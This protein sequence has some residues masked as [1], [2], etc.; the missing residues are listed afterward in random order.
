MDLVISAV[1]SDLASRFISFI[2]NRL[3]ISSCAEEKVERLQRLLQRVETVVEEANGRYIPN[4]VM[5]SQL[6]ILEEAMYLSYHTLYTFKYRGLEG[7]KKE[8]TDGS[9]SLY[10]SSPLKHSA[11]S[12]VQC[13]FD[14]GDKL[15][16]AMASL[17]AVVTNMTEFVMLLGGCERMSR[18]PYDTYLY[19]E[20]FMFGRHA[21]MQ[22]A[23]NILL[24]PP[25][26]NN[27]PTVLPIIGGRFIG[28]KTLVAHQHKSDNLQ[29]MDSQR[30]SSGRALI[31]VELTTDI[32]DEEWAKFYSSVPEMGEGSKVI[33][34]TRLRNLSRFGSTNMEDHPR[35]ASMVQE[36]PLLLRGSLISAYAFAD[37]L[38]R[39]LS[40]LF[41]A[42]VLDRFRGVVESNLSLFG[43][44]PK[45]LLDRDLP[46]DMARFI[47]PSAAPLR[48]MPPRSEADTQERPLP[49]LTFGE[50]I[51][52]PRILPRGDFDLVTW[53][54]K[55][56]PYSKYV[57]FVPVAYAEEKPEMWP[58]RRKRRAVSL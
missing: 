16:S 10:F 12:A 50:L 6:R 26:N 14:N 42:S 49:M 37:I 3:S 40:P 5:L 39:N 52:D 25:L 36:F 31:I 32:G 54:S 41:W 1:A 35:L 24:Q 7:A 30:H 13:S 45:L 17:E 18:R 27:A 38:K 21:E 22:Q 15:Q 2:I 57:H 19:M 8:V 55:I 51:E 56:A 44:H 43:E 34:I 11:G 53:E 20:N 48:L 46:T 58:T 4:S 33:L 23:I 28:K 9:L 47:S 29:I